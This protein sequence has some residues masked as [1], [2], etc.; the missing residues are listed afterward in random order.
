MRGA[1]GQ[2]D[3]GTGRVC[4]ELAVVELFAHPDIED[5]GDDRVDAI[6][7][8]PVRHQLDA[9]GHLHPDHVGAGRGGLTHHDGEAGRRRER[10]ERLPVDVLG[11]D[12]PEDVLAWLVSG[13]H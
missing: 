7:R 6:L 1:A 9:R 5:T 4:L 2:D 8:V 10:G 13:H 12:R 11:P 3:D